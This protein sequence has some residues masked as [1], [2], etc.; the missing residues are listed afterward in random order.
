L[1]FSFHAKHFAFGDSWYLPLSAPR[2]AA[3]PTIA[4]RK[5]GIHRALTHRINERPCQ[6]LARRYWQSSHPNNQAELLDGWFR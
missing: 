5:V 4:C 6:M 3:W 1:N 2:G